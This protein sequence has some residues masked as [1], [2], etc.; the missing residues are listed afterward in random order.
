[1]HIGL[2]TLLTLRIRRQEDLE[3]ASVLKYG[4]LFQVYSP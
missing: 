1:M 2:T 3:G 4:V